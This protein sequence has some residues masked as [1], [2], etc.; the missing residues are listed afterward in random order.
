M[1]RKA[2][3]PVKQVIKRPLTNA[4]Q[5][6][7][8]RYYRGWRIGLALSAV[9]SLILLAIY[10]FLPAGFGTHQ[11]IYSDVTVGELVYPAIV[12]VMLVFSVVCLCG[13]FYIFVVRKKVKDALNGSAL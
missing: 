3:L 10:E 2:V 12:L 4:E 13:S 9:I 6:V 8:L 1:S 7:L 5:A 11:V